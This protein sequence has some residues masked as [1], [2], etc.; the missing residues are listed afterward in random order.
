[1]TTRENLFRPIHKGIRSMIYE[2]GLRLGVADFTNVEETNELTVQLQHDLTGSISNCILCMLQAHSRHE[3]R[4]YFAA[5]EP[6]DRDVVE[7]M[8]VEH[9][10]IASQVLDVSRTC[11]ELRGLTDLKRRIEVGDRLFLEANDLF[12]A[13]LAHLNNE[14]ATLVPVMWERFTDEKLRALRAQFYNSIPLPRFEDWMRW[15]L[16]ALNLNE[17][18]VLLSGMRVEPGPNRFGDAMR[19][20]AETLDPA[21]WNALQERVGR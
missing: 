13:Y 7:L 4:D 17:L 19:V 9:R 2:L 3:E 14:E 21:R 16:P 11:E 5:I 1:M 8:M 18:E 6:F 12:A 15:T 10:Q 20:A